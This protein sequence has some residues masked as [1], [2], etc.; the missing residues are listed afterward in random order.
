[1]LTMLDPEV[2]AVD[3]VSEVHVNVTWERVW[4]PERLSEGGRGSGMGSGLK[5]HLYSMTL[6]GLS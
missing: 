4:T 2:G 6:D 1:M 5:V 3:G